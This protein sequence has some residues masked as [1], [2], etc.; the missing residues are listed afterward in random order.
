MSSEG[1]NVSICMASVN[2]APEFWG[3]DGQAF[4]PERWFGTEIGEERLKEV[5]GHR[6]L[7]TFIDGAR[8]SVNHCGSC[9]ARRN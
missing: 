3:S 8:T 9:S 4:R 2:R 1:A 5:Q 7:L 6:H